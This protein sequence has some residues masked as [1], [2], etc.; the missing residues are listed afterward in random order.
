MFNF[1]STREL[2]L[3][4]WHTEMQDN[5]RNFHGKFKQIAEIKLKVC[6][7]WKNGIDYTYKGYIGNITV[8]NE[9]SNWK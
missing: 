7:F 1:N 4:C 9:L 2:K 3:F 6:I 8:I 5:H